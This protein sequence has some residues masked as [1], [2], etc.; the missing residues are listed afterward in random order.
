MT[1]CEFRAESSVSKSFIRGHDV[2]YAFADGY[3]RWSLPFAFSATGRES[4]DPDRIRSVEVIYRAES[5]AVR[6][7]LPGPV[8]AARRLVYLPSV[9]AGAVTLGQ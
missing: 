9:H 8:S 2:R 6:I 5:G 3:G 1:V 4:I 7:V